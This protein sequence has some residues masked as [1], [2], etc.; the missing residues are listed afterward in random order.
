MDGVVGVVADEGS[1]VP[2]VD[3]C[4]MP[5]FVL[6]LDVEAGGPRLLLPT[7]LLIVVDGVMA[8]GADC[9][10]W[11]LGCSCSSVVIA[12]AVE[13]DDGGL[14]KATFDWW[15]WLLFASRR[16][17]DSMQIRTVGLPPN[18]GPRIGCCRRDR[19]SST[20]CE[21]HNNNKRNYYYYYY[22][23]GH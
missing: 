11:V 12:V 16:F 13:D 23:Y 8:V 17:I 21:Y 1:T 3:F 4:S 14:L 9:F 15:W 22:Y 6:R 10:L 5:L 20:I 18:A 2:I 7:P 19:S